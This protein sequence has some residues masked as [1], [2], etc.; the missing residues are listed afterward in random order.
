MKTFFTLALITFISLI[1]YVVLT[2][3]FGNIGV[4]LTILST[5]VL[6]LLFHAKQINSVRLGHKIND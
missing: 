5:V 1:L 4:L 3:V 6:Y 2:D